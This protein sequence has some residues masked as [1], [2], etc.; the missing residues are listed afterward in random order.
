MRTIVS[1]PT[2]N[3]QPGASCAFSTKS[4]A[5]VSSTCSAGQLFEPIGDLDEVERRFVDVRDRELERNGLAQSFRGNLGHALVGRVQWIERAGKQD[6][7]AVVGVRGFGWNRD[8]RSL[9]QQQLG[10]RCWRSLLAAV[11]YERQSVRIGKRS[12]TPQASATAFRISCVATCSSSAR[13]RA[14]FGSSHETTDVV[15]ADCQAT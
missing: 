3:V 2:T 13:V 5:R 12:S 11:E 15:S 9:A 14:P 1:M 6:R 7:C 10:P 4:G 8:V